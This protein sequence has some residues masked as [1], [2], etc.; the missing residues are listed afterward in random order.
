MR[1]LLA[2]PLLSFVLCL[3]CLASSNPL[4]G[5]HIRAISNPPIKILDDYVP[6]TGDRKVSK[7]MAASSDMVKVA[8][9]APEAP[10]DNMVAVVRKYKHVNMNDDYHPEDKAIELKRAAE[11]PPEHLVVWAAKGVFR[12]GC[13]VVNHTM[14]I[15]LGCTANH[16]LN[17]AAS[18]AVG[19]GFY[20]LTLSLTGGNVFIGNFM[21]AFG[22]QTCQPIIASLVFYAGAH[23]PDIIYYLGKG[24]YKTVHLTS[25]TAILLFR[26]FRCTGEYLDEFLGNGKTRDDLI[27]MV[28]LHDPSIIDLT[29]KG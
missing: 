3:D 20:L 18:L 16:F 21:Y 19:R 10:D 14:R 8:D 29:V 26:G 27:E 23:T 13:R 9:N 1:L 17:H 5:E 28:K 12:G 25:K 6:Q 2:L 4:E 11:K 24:V 7:A 22:A 15:A